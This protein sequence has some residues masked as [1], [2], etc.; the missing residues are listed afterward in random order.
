MGTTRN[1]VTHHT[2]AKSSGNFTYKNTKRVT[3]FFIVEQKPTVSNE[4]Q[5]KNEQNTRHHITDNNPP[6]ISQKSPAVVI[7]AD[8][9]ELEW[10]HDSIRV[11]APPF[12]TPLL[13]FPR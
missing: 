6:P 12:Q 5:T 13:R 4:K 3:F 1:I 9:I 2:V 8:S 10:A 7:V 11:H